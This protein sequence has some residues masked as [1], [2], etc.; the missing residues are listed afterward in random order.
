[1]AEPTEQSFNPNFRELDIES[2]ISAPLVAASKANVVM[3][4]GQTRFLL[5][6]CFTKDDRNV[7]TPIMIVMSLSRGVI[8]ESKK[9]GEAGRIR[10]VQMTFSI[11]LLCIVP[12][13]SL[14]VDKV[15]I[16]FDMEITSAIPKQAKAANGASQMVTEQNARLNGRIG[17]AQDDTEG[18]RGRSQYRHRM[19]SRLKVSLNASPLPLPNGVLAILDLY[20]R[21]IQ[22]LPAAEHASAAIPDQT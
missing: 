6:Y 1:M 19:S 11:P 22:P 8:D 5:E 9:E 3:V 15:S 13:N 10:L 18:G 21:S 20:T 12:I 4:T 14:V 7:Y 17:N 16:D 2:M